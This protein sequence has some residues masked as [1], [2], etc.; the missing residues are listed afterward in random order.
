M[1]NFFLVPPE[2]PPV[3]ILRFISILLFVWDIRRI[4]SVKQGEE[5]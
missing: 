4:G 1:K 2:K 3:V 5:K